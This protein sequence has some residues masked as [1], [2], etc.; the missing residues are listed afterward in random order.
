ML[1]GVI[2]VTGAIYIL[3]LVLRDTATALGHRVRSKASLKFRRMSNEE[4]R[5]DNVTIDLPYLMR[6][7]K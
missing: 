3:F 1:V 7:K 2:M 5:R 4:L 6:E